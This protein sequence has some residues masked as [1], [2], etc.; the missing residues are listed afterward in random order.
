MKDLGYGE[1]YGYDH[2]FPEHV[3]PQEYLPDNI[4]GRAYYEPGELGFEKR[5]SER[6]AYWEKLRREAMM[7][8]A[9]EDAGEPGEA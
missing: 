4:K 2:D 8:Q 3:A 7:R 1:G 9:E 6:M 5:V